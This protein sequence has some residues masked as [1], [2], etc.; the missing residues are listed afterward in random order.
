[1]RLNAESK[2]LSDEVTVYQDEQKE[3][4]RTI[5]ELREKVKE[6][7]MKAL[8]PSKFME[9][10][11][12][13]IHFWIMGLEGGRFKKY[14]TVLKDSLSADEVMGEDLLNVNPLVLKAWGV[15]DRKDSKGLN[16]YI[17]DLVAQNQTV[18]EQPA[19]AAPKQNEGA[20]TAY[21]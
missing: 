19:M 14:E 5:A 6:L 7:E 2:K 4:E 8:D 16:K 10:D 3:A 11:C 21:M 12:N 1:M 9:W 13:Q 17:Q 20:P 15:K 18:Y